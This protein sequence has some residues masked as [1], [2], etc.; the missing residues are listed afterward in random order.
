MSAIVP[1][2]SRSL[3]VNIYA[4]STEVG[5]YAN[6]DGA[7]VS[8]HL[9]GNCVGRPFFGDVV[10]LGWLS[11]PFSIVIVLTA[12]GMIGWVAGV[13]SLADVP[14]V[15]AGAFGGSFVVAFHHDKRAIRT[16]WR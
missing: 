14:W 7:D 10:E 1:K 2:T 12:I 15:L 9:E 13:V 4:A 16:T 3:S 5:P 6:L 8:R 11:T